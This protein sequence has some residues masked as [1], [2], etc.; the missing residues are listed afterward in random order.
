MFIKWSKQL[1]TYLKGEKCHLIPQLSKNDHFI[2]HFI[3][4]TV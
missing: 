1:M 2:Y 3:Y 4:A